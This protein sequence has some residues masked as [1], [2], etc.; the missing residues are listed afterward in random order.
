M[1]E[2]QYTIEILD[3]DDS[4]S[5]V[6][7]KKSCLIGKSLISD[8]RIHLPTIKEMHL[9]IDMK[10]KRV[11]S[12]GKDVKVNEV[13]LDINK[14][15]D[16]EYGDVISL[17]NKRFVVHKNTE[18]KE[19][20]GLP[21]IVPPER[22]V[23]NKALAFDLRGRFNLSP[24]RPRRSDEVVSGSGDDEAD[25]SEAQ[26]GEQL[27][28]A[29]QQKCEASTHGQS[30]F[31]ASDSSI[32]SL[33]TQGK[34]L[35]GEEIKNNF[36]LEKDALETP[37]YP[38]NIKPM[39]LK[40]AVIGKMVLED[41]RENPGNVAEMERVVKGISEKDENTN[42]EQDSE[43]GQPL[44]MRENALQAASP[45][46][47]PDA[48]PET[49]AD[50][51]PS[52]PITD[53]ETE[54]TA[55]DAQDADQSNASDSSSPSSDR[56][57]NREIKGLKKSAE[58]SFKTKEPPMEKSKASKNSKRSENNNEKK[59]ATTD[60]NDGAKSGSP[61]S[62]VA[63]K[64]K[65][66]AKPEKKGAMA[67]ATKEVQTKETQAVKKG[68]LVNKASVNASAKKE[69]ANAPL[70]TEASDKD[71]PREK[72]AANG[73]AAEA[74]KKNDELSQLKKK[75]RRASSTAS[76]VPKKEESVKKMVAKK[77]APAAKKKGQKA[78]AAK[79]ARK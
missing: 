67:A 6:T 28:A 52:A 60:V 40:E 55:A 63:A 2:E 76:A 39:D 19:E 66:A 47:T 16:Y 12:Y 58:N 42:N 18:K 57:G 17:R 32:D 4:T 69:N 71:S 30:F 29:R 15:V 35:I 77:K 65:A 21:L 50:I 26:D 74:E 51:A 3:K 14:T 23:D 68:T 10:N 13:G 9:E 62:K 43:S 56:P 70:K 54:P 61:L 46:Q 27:D 7:S 33:I 59:S 34:T 72:P 20:V 37:A 45:Q 78:K 31:N 1:E 5:L 8:I 49:S 48:E 11:T 41:I 73:K 79:P 44:D 36:E 64:G 24:N 75:V 25:A 38:R 22:A 53:A